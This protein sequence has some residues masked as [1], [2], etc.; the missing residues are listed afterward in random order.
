M[1]MRFRITVQRETVACVNRFVKGARR[2][3]NFGFLDYKKHS[4][5]FPSLKIT[6]PFTSVGVAVVRKCT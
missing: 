2:I 5:W 4:P 3:S 1:I 6:L